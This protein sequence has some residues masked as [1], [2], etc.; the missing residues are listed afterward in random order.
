[1]TDKVQVIVKTVTNDQYTYFI[2]SKASI[3]DLKLLIKEDYLGNPVP[4]AQKIIIGGTVR[5]DNAIIEDLFKQVSY[6]DS[7]IYVC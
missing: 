3:L 2:S 4:E 7:D 1:M 5:E 6:L